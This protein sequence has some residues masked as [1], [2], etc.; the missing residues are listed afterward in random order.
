M[1][2]VLQAVAA[3]PI[4]LESIMF[5]ADDID[6]FWMIPHDPNGS[7]WFN[8]K[9]LWDGYIVLCPVFWSCGSKFSQID[10]L[11]PR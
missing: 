8:V 6:E 3:A 4:L 10:S 7:L 11:L 9:E 5:E 1:P 2:L